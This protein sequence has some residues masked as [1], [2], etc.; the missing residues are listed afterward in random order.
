MTDPRS[1]NTLRLMLLV[2]TTNSPAQLPLP[3]MPSKSQMT[4]GFCTWP[5]I[6]NAAGSSTSV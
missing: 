4:P 1:K 3:A 5:L 2:T 6:Q